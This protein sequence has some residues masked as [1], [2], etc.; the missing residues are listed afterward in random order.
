MTHYKVRITLTNGDGIDE[1]DYL[2]KSDAIDHM[3]YF[4]DDEDESRMD[5]SDRWYYE[6]IEVFENGK[7]IAKIA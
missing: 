4:A 5:E 2:R 6:M 3:N 1:Y 7:L